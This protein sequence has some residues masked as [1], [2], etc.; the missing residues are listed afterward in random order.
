MRTESTNEA[1]APRDGRAESDQERH[2]LIARLFLIG[3]SVLGRSNSFTR[4]PRRAP[5]SSC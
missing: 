5:S 2:D 3:K 4:R 1:R